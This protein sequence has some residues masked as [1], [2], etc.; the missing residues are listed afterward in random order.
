MNPTI[1]FSDDGPDADRLS[2]FVD[3]QG[4]VYIGTIRE[5]ERTCMH[6]T[7]LCG[8]G[9]GCRVPEVRSAVLLLASVARGDREQIQSSMR[10]LCVMLSI[11]PMVVTPMVD[12]SRD[13]FGPE[14]IGPDGKVWPCR[15][16]HVQGCPVDDAMRNR[17]EV[18]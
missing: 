2:I 7:R 4:D 12:G 18:P 17:G 3:D 1:I 16:D 11:T 8:I 9:G 15:D 13:L 14:C 5:G 6:A 10:S